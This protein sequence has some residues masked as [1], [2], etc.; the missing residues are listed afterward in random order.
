M[1]EFRSFKYN[2]HTE[3]LF[4]CLKLLKIEHVLKLHELKLYYKF[5]H[6]KLPVYLQNLPIHQNNSTQNFNTRGQY[7]IHTIRVQHEFAKQS[8]RYTLPHST[9]NAP[10]LVKNK[11]NNHSLHGFVMYVKH[12]YLHTFVAVYTL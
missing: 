6:K 5:A 1:I 4:K 8:I 2:A 10:D 12:Y 9:N 3:P 7:N 11:K